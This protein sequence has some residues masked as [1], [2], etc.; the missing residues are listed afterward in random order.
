MEIKIG[1]IKESELDIVYTSYY[2]FFEQL[3]G[4]NVW[5]KLTT[6]LIALGEGVPYII[7]L[8]DSNWERT[9]N[10]VKSAYSELG[11][12]MIGAYDSYNRL[13]ALGRVKVGVPGNT[14]NAIVGEMI[15]VN[16]YLS[17]EKRTDLYGAMVQKVEELYT[18]S[19]EG[20]D[21]LTFE[22]PENDMPYATAVAEQG[23]EVMTEKGEGQVTDL[24]D[25][26]LR[27]NKR[28]L[29]DH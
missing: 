17:A 4:K 28:R 2:K 21:M 16:E 8:V 23:Y 29:K 18:T 20:V 5:S 3:Y 14:K 6:K 9:I 12:T 13:L 19:L 11:C 25:K 1:I 10:A 24:Y 7:E 15:I 26:D 22:V 27:Q